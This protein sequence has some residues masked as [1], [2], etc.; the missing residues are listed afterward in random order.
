M[1]LIC[2]PW[3]LPAALAF[4]AW[5]AVMPLPAAL[6]AALVLAAP[7]SA[8]RWDMQTAQFH[9]IGDLTALLLLAAVGYFAANTED[10][11]PVHA[12][13]RWAPALA[14]PLLLAQLY[15]NGQLLPLSAVF[16]SLRRHREARPASFDF[17]LPY[18][19]LCVLAAG[20]AVPQNNHYFV[21]AALLTLWLL[22]TRQPRRL[23]LA[24]WLPAY[25]LACAL[26]Y[27]GQLG[28][29]Q[30]QTAL[31]EWTVEWF[32]AWD[33]DPF[34]ARTAMGDVGRLKLSSRVLLTVA[35]D[36]PPSQRLL[37]KDAAYDRYVGQGW[38]ASLA[39]F[40][41]YPVPQGDGPEAITLQHRHAQADVLLALPAGLRGLQGIP[42]KALV[43]NHLGA[44]KW[45]DAPPML[46]YRAR[47]D[48]AEPDRSPP[49]AN[50]TALPEA[51]AKL[52]EPL[53]R[54]LGLRQLPPTRA[55]AV[56][57]DWFA[58]QFGY[59]L[60]TGSH[61]NHG[62]A[63]EHFLYRHHAGHCEYFA[64]ATAL[65]LRAAAVP[66]RYATG[67]AVQEYDAGSQVFLVRQRHA[68]AW[69]E[70]YINGAW[71][72]LDYTPSRWAEEEA[73]ADPW[74]HAVADRWSLWTMAFNAWRWE[75]AQQGEKTGVPWW[76][77]LAL[78][79]AGWL[80]LRLYRSRQ[81]VAR[82]S[83]GAE[84]KADA[85]PPD[86]EYAQLE[87]NLLAA[88]HPPREPG[89]TPL[90]WLR[91]L[92]LQQTHGPK[93]LA[94]YRRRHGTHQSAAKPLKP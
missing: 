45:Q 83:V 51:T 8:W 39:H 66:T 55:A 22:W 89:E 60:D 50:E 67:Y 11:L 91:R 71:R 30:L 90:R 26:G 92:G 44:V 78:P 25:A 72:V 63:L 17:R 28:L 10:V 49:A 37:L 19:L 62:D 47:Y 93:V 73:Q 31:E 34:K 23:A 77:W 86:I 24:L 74:W 88:G 69:A 65:L 21:G 41:P 85:K 94:Y 4:W 2:P 79:L 14:A 16:Y 29:S 43:R 7:R 3:L 68:H 9:R 27:F 48:P 64:T 42:E 5:Q 75:Q 1:E 84:T 32:S 76:A 40:Q 46:R 20:S 70:A 57:S 33:T 82:R 58:T 36:H 56:L 13:L 52:L 38:V 35:F 6:I 61:A 54:Q 53:V 87:Q 80:G 15:S 12:V 18:A 81:H 59:S